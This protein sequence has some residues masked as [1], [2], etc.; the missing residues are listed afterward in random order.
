MVCLHFF[1]FLFYNILVGKGLS[2]LF[3]T[4]YNFLILQEKKD[5]KESVSN[6]YI[7]QLKELNNL[8]ES[9]QKELTEVNRILAEQ[10]HA[11]E[12]LDERLSASVQSCTEANEIINR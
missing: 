8:L 5:L 3:S 4:N 10:K 1:W 11:L 9:K 7:D 6:S 2:P 12:D